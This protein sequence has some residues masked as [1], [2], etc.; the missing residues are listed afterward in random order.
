METITHEGKLYRKVARKAVEGDSWVVPKYNELD[1]TAG[2]I[3]SVVG[4]SPGGNPKI[5]D[6]ALDRNLIVR[7]VYVLELVTADQTAPITLISTTPAV[8]KTYTIQLTEHAVVELIRALNRYVFY[9]P[10]GKGLRD[11]FEAIRQS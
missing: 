11:Q 3:Y 8:E 2:R 4:L 9:V 6:D 5:V 1:I 10:S 7:D